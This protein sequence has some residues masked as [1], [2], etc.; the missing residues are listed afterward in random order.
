MKALLLFTALFCA[1][2]Q[3]DLAP[4]PQ[5]GEVPAFEF[6]RSNGKKLSRQDLLGQVW[7]ADFIFTRCGGQCPLL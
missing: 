7:V 5:L 2:T 6:T 4:L 3:A 1:A